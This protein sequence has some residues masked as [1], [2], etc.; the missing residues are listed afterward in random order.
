VKAGRRSGRATAF[1]SCRDR[2]PCGSDPAPSG[3][4]AALAAVPGFRHARPA[5]L[6]HEHRPR[7]FVV[8]LTQSII[9]KEFALSGSE[10]NPDITGKSW[11]MTAR[12]ATNKGAPAPVEAFKSHG[13]DFCRARQISP[14]SSAP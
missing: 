5:A 12:R 11:L 4:R 10:Q 13:V 9:K 2:H 6:H 1:A 3:R 14:I 8:V 7:L